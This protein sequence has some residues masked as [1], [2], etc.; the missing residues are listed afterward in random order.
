MIQQIA[1]TFYRFVPFNAEE[2]TLSSSANITCRVLFFMRVQCCGTGIKAFRRANFLSSNK[3][4]LSFCILHLIFQ[5]ITV[6]F[7]SK[8]KAHL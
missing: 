4:I 6:D 1:L 7:L 5:P 8:T 3:Q 2:S